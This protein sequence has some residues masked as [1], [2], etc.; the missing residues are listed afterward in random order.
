MYII[1]A[2]L[3]L[4]V[5]IIGHEYGHFLAARLSGIQVQEF[6]VGMGPEL[7]SRIGKNGTKFSLRL[8]PIG[9][10]C[11]FYDEDA[12]TGDPRAFGKQSVW[13]RM[14]T[15][16]CGPLTNFLLAFVVVVFYLS[17]VGILSIVPKVA[18][19]EEN[20][21]SAGLRVGDEII[22]ANETKV[23]GDVSV[24]S[25]A[26]MKSGGE[27]V[28]LTVKRGQTE[29]EITVKPFYDEESERYRLGFTYGEERVRV[30]VT[31]SAPFSVR[32]N[33]ESATI[34]TRTLRDLVTKGQGAG[35]VTGVVGTVYV[36]QEVTRTGGIDIYLELMAMIS[37]NLGIMNLLPI[38]GLDGSRLVFLLIE[39]VRGKPIKKEIEGSIHLA[40]MV[41][42]MALMVV[43][44][45]KDVVTIL[46]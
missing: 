43:L 37:V 38:P 14:L 44:T 3:L 8:L 24:V 19:I 33:A 26:I 30:P 32:Y 34:I 31:Q 11:A 16:A 7:F 36:I 13:K 27:P 28:T 20:A 41:F 46:G 5:L 25:Q 29:E 42:L 12:E 15:V 40:G 39:A 6:S 1:L 4:G 17:A 18:Q 21:A 45:F 9:G 10:F 35:D 22:A 2:F 23:E